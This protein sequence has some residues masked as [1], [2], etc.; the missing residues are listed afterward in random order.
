MMASYMHALEERARW[1]RFAIDYHDGK[2]I[3]RGQ[4]SFYDQTMELYLHSLHAGDTFFM[5]RQ[6]CELVDHARIDVPD[7]LIF[8]ESWMHTK[9]GFLWLEVPFSV[10]QPEGE[11]AEPMIRAVSWIAN[12]NGF[13]FLTYLEWEIDEAAFG[14][15]TH[16]S[17]KQG[18]VL[19][20]RITE[21][22]AKV[23]D[24][25]DNAGYPGKYPKT[26]DAVQ[27]HE[28][29]WVYAAMHL[30]AQRLACTVE[31][32]ASP[33]ARDSARRKKLT[34][35]PSLRVVT[36]RRMEADRPKNGEHQARE[37]QWQWLVGGHWRLQ[38]YKT[39]GDYRW[40]FIE[41]YVKG[42][43]DKPLKPPTHTLFKAQR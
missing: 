35:T 18:D 39:I 36:L 15:W 41:S 28:M 5:N 11:T 12:K 30:M 42:P 3:R 37:W 34:I 9:S 17:F 31:H 24:P 6:F 38:P 19:S 8:E 32:R 23:H 33:M 14:C 29:R 16:F 20:T 13:I 26:R 40:I 27:R 7:D 43:Q 21:F 22:E 10:P 2:I 1:L 4:H 25:D